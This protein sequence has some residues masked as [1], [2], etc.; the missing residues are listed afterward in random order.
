M[1][2]VTVSPAPAPSTTVDVPGLAHDLR[3]L[4]GR[5]VR[6]QRASGPDIGITPLQYS[7]LARLEREGPTTTGVLALAER[8]SAQAVGQNVAT[9]EELGLVRRTG[10]VDDGRK[11]VLCITSSGVDLVHH[12]R[13]SRESWL[14]AGLGTIDTKDLQT[15]ASAVTILNRLLDR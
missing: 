1:D 7:L 15:L 5:M 13:G 9:L 14:A 3:L 12:A 2:S 6:H 11:V 10:H 8:V 4:M